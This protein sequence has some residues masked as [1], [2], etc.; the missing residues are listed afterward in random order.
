[1]LAVERKVERD[2]IGYC[3]L[4]E[5]G[6]ESDGEPKLA[7]EVLRRDWSLGYATEASLAV[8]EWARSSGHERLWATVWGWNA[9]SSSC[10]GQ[11]RIHRRANGTGPYPWEQPRH[12]ETALTPTLLS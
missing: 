1:L 4:I 11:G 10:A 6:Q 12:D 3:G 8:L 9:A 5:G 7:F 2:I